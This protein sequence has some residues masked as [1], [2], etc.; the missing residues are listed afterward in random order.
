MGNIMK[1]ERMECIFIGFVKSKRHL[2]RKRVI[3]EGYL[4]LNLGGI[5]QSHAGVGNRKEIWAIE[6][7]ENLKNL[8][9]TVTELL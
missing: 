8:L 7:E 2:G 4:H 9:S 5:I 6:L 1:F 3:F